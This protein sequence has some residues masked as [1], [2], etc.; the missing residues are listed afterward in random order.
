[1]Y[2]CVY[3]TSEILVTIVA[4]LNPSTLGRTAW[5]RHPTVAALLQMYTPNP[6]TTRSNSQG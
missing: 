1:M 2:I 5:E 3:I 4:T 6:E